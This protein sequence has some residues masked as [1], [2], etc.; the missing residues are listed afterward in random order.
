MIICDL[1]REKRR[2]ENFQPGPHKR[3]PQTTPCLQR[4]GGYSRV[5]RL[6]AVKDGKRTQNSF[7]D[8]KSS[9]DGSKVRPRL[10]QKG[11]NVRLALVELFS[12]GITSSVG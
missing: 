12:G 3:L 2:R 4:G 5:E 8:R 9:V 1:M 11:A 6:A 7:G 10:T